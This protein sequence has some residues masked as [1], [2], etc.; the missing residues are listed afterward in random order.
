[1]IL[2]KWTSK[3]VDFVLAFPQADIECDMYMDIPQRY[4]FKGSNRTHCLRLRK[5][6]YGQRQAG[7]VFNQYLHSGMIA[8]GFK[9]S[10]IDMCVYY[11]GNVSLLIYTDDGIFIGPNQKEIQECYDLLSAKFVDNKGTEHRAFK[12]SDEGDLADYLGVK[13]TP[14]KTNGTIKLSQPHLINTIL[15]DLGMVEG[16]KSKPTP[17]VASKLLSRDIHGQPIDE[18][19]NYRSIVGKLNFLEKST[20]PDI[21]YATHQCARF[22]ADPKVSH[23]EA[24]K[25]IGR[26][27]VGNKD[28]G[29]ILNPQDHS[30]DTWVD[31]DFVGNWDRVNADKDP[32]TAKSRTGYILM[33]AGCPI[34]WA[35]KIQREVSLSS[36][37]SEY[38]ALSESLRHVIHMMYLVDEMKEQGYKISTAPPK[39]HCKVFEDNAGCL[40]M[41]RLPKMRPR[42]KHLCV[43]LHH[44]REHVRK[45]RISIH[46]VPTELQLADIATKP[47]PEALFV[48]QRES[49]LQ[50]ESEDMSLADLKL[51]AKHLRACE[52]IRNLEVSGASE[53]PKGSPGSPKGA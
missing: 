33:Y 22:C 25:R 4:K 28:K 44:F 19:W 30:F 34:V 48:S 6:L 3:Q 27:L 29:I 32:S 24:V 16:T 42:T 50:W 52:I 10:K 26:Y 53:R 39:V 43:K 14:H 36:T 23:A 41:A 20:R 47:Q 49:I 51:D 31:A 40:E 18:K 8:R 9:Q 5:N 45:G 7:R 15:T 46:K 11:R 37:E 13:I 12:M 2:N 17:A 38:N 1:M 35:S 21:A